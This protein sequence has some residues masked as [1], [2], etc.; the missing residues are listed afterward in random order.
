VG[1]SSTAGAV[2]RSSYQDFTLHL[3]FREPFQPAL[4]GTSRGNSGVYLQ[5]RY[6]VQILDSFGSNLATADTMAP[7]RESGAIFEH[8]G[9]RL[10]MSFPPRSWQTYDIL[11]TA[12]RFDAAG[13]RTAPAKVTVR[14]NG[15][16]VQDGRDMLNYTLAGEPEGASAG[17]LRFQAYDSPVFYRNIW[18]AEGASSLAPGTKGPSPRRGAADGRPADRFATADG[19]FLPSGPAAG[20]ARAASGAYLFSVPGKGGT[21]THSRG[22]SDEL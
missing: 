10:N 9:P 11:F 2:T 8:F 19:R 22:A 3:E 7:K 6:E 14:L 12:A 20:D 1:A 4:R 18:V 17:P 13:K 16:A 21:L 15:E 5:S